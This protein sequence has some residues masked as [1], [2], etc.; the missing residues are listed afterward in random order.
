LPNNHIILS[1][2][3]GYGN[4]FQHNSSNLEK[5]YNIVYPCKH[6][7]FYAS[8][9]VRNI[10]SI[11]E[12][13]GPNTILYHHYCFHK[14]CGGCWGIP[15]W[16]KNISDALSVLKGLKNSKG[17]S[18]EFPYQLSRNKIVDVAK[19]EIRCTSGVLLRL[20]LLGPSLINQLF[21]FS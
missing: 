10:P 18:T 2:Y 11:S 17:H 19:E 8:W 7:K 15:L 5:N 3:I 21:P 1:Y 13:K 12:K 16:Q 9:K 6:E 4:S 20:E 14:N